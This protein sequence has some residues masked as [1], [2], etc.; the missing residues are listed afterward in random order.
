MALINPS[1]V[2]YAVDNPFDHPFDVDKEQG[3]DALEIF[4]IIRTIRDPEHPHTLQQLNV[5]QQQLIECSDEYVYL[6]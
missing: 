6:I 2:I 1:P 4:E 3:I 5:A